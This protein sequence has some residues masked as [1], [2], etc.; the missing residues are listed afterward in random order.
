MSI[1]PLDAVSAGFQ[2]VGGIVNY[3]DAKKDKKQ[4]HE[5]LRKSK[6]RLDASKEAFKNLDTSNP[7]LN[8][9]NVY[10]DMTVN[11]QEAEFTRQQQFQ[12]QANILQQLR[13][14]AGTSGI[15][16]LAQA[17]A[18]QGALDAQ[19]AAVSIG[20]QEASIQEKKLGEESKLQ[21]LER[22]GDLISR[23]AEASKLGSLMAMD[24]QEVAAQ[25]L[26][27]Q[28]AK[29]RMAQAFGGIGSGIIDLAAASEV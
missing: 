6:A 26:A 3:F 10:E 18:N 11:Q 20:K 22:E 7:Y 21:G 25:R 12:N 23:Q 24:A 4:L 28:Q 19:K 29:E 8:M 13:G 1:G 17:L 16:G 5:K 9:Q 2:V 15:A 14:A 27:Q